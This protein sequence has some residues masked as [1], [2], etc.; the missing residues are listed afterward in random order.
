MILAG[1]EVSAFWTTVTSLLG[2]LCASVIWVGFFPNEFVR[3]R[4]A[5]VYAS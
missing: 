4:V 1:P 3:S 5:R 2:V